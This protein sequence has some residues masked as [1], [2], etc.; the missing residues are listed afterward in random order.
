MN[1]SLSPA[2]NKPIETTTEVVSDIGGILTKLSWPDEI[3][4]NQDNKLGLQFSDAL[5]DSEISGDIHYDITFYDQE[6]NEVIKKE[7]LVANNA[8]DSQIFNFPEKGTYQIEI[9]VK[10]I[11]YPGITSPDETRN[12]ISRGN[13][14]IS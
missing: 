3:K 9:E 1:F 5:S 2:E 6:G 14:I 10:S 4:A 12:G 8:T 11:N 13:V 7:N